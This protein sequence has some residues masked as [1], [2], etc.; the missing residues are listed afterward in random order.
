VRS[1]K[2]WEQILEVAREVRADLIVVGSHG[3]KLIQR[4]LL[5]SVAE[6]VVRL[7][8]VPVLTVHPPMP[9]AA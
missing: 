8:H 9:A 2:A 6:R 4:A 5:G 3:R 1:G 7:S